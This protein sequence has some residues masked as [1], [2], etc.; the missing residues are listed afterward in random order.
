I[1]GED[2]MPMRIVEGLELVPFRHRRGREGRE[3]MI[4][5]RRMFLALRQ[6]E[7]DLMRG[8]AG[9]F[10]GDGG[11]QRVELVFEE[12]LPV[13]LLD[14]AEAIGYHLDLARRSAVADIVESDLGGPEPFEKRR[15]VLRQ[16]GKDETAVIADARRRLHVAER[17][18]GAVAGQ[19]RAVIAALERDGLERAVGMKLPGMVGADE[20]LGHAAVAVA[21]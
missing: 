18:I 12:N 16:A 7:L 2:R 11:M 20:A 17:A 1:A 15:A 9:R 14:H 19:P 5:K 13:R 6:G 3:E 4:G 21:A 10:M 8:L